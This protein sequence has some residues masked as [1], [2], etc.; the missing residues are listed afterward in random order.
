MFTA[1]TYLLASSLEEAYDA[2][3]KNKTNTLVAG[4]CWL[5]MTRKRIWTAVDISRLGLDSIVPDGDTL[6]IGAMASLHSLETDPAVKGFAGGILSE[7]VRR[8]VGVQFRNCATVGGCVWMRAGFSDLLTA[9]LALDTT[10]C[11]YH[12]GQ[13]PLDEF[14]VAWNNL[15][16]CLRP[17]RHGIPEG[18][19]ARSSVWLREDRQDPGLY[20]MHLGGNPH[21]LP[22]DFCGPADTDADPA[23]DAP[24]EPAAG[25]GVLAWSLPD[26][27]PHATA[28]HRTL[29]FVR[30]EKGGIRLARPAE[31]NQPPLK[32]TV[33][34]IDPAGQTLVGDVLVTP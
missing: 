12:A 10:V 5:K 30:P 4:C 3:Q 7:A 11:L 28:A 14:L 27:I 9:L 16:L 24:A 33:Y 1:K 21:P 26:S 8:I 22:D 23:A 2:L 32:Y 15:A 29:H 13:M 18:C 19:P 17:R 34:A 25:V 20:Q 6:Q 31:N